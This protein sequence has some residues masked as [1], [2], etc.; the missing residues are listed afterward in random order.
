MQEEFWLVW[1][2][3]AGRPTKKHPTPEAAFEEAERLTKSTGQPFHVLGCVDTCIPGPVTW[4]H[5][6]PKP[7][8]LTGLK[9]EPQ[10]PEAQADA[11]PSSKTR[12][13]IGVLDRAQ[14]GDIVLCKDERTV[15]DAIVSNMLLYPF[16]QLRYATEATVALLRGNP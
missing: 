7:S 10:E 9:W 6:S 16:K 13:I 11:S 15:N 4:E 3:T 8:P 1:C 2:E 12:E 14:D 5:G